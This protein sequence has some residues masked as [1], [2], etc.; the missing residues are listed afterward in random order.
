MIKCFL[1]G[2]LALM[3]LVQAPFIFAL[4]CNAI[5]E[6][7]KQA[8]LDILNSG[9]SLEEQEALIS[10][11]EYSKQFFP[12]H[13]YIYLKNNVIPISSA[14]NGVQNYNGIFV[15]NAWMS[16]F[17]AM[18]SVFYNNS[19][20]VPNKTKIL[21]GFNYQIQ[22]PSNYYSSGY[23]STNQGDCKRIY[24][25]TN[26]YAE[27]KIYVNNNYQSS[28][29]LAEVSINQDSQIKSVYGINVAY[30]VDHYYWQRYCSRY[31]NGRCVSHSYRCAFNYNEVKQDNIAI[32]DYLNVKSYKNNLIGNITLIGS[33]DR[34]GIN[35][36]NAFEL[37]TNSSQYYFYDYAYTINYSKAPYY[38]QTLVAEN[39][40]QE[41]T[42][43]VQRFNND[44]L[45]K[46]LDSC[47]I[48]A[49]DFFNILYKDCSVTSNPI[50]LSIETDKLTYNPNET[51]KV[52][53]YPSNIPINV[54]Y[55]NESKLIYGTSTF[56]VNAPYNKL[57]A[58][59][60]EFKS[61][62]IIF[63]KDPSKTSTIFS[64][65]IFGFLNYVF[66][67]VLRKYWGGIL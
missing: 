21:T 47:K 67:A 56:I 32:T 8:C 57:T 16:I 50:N 33:N 23:P 55:G 11:L 22:A 15:K 4:D 34:I 25:Q 49:F 5:S 45:I 66:Y 39:Y 65:S 42:N 19:L 43:N 58:T 17:T 18:P 20:Y 7:N 12:D 60:E 27:N 36:S 2:V 28:G 54:S 30:K 64:L 24:T 3:I 53:V 48:R 31:R 35:K 51:I 62:K 46:N 37:E 9:L 29:K 41:F 61:E 59:Y 44:L 52:S 10:N 38:V 1:F 14:P 40:N 26:N 63:I 13:N 6:T